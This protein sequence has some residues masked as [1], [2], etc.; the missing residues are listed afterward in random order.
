MQMTGRHF[1][2]I[3]QD[4]SI[5]IS[6]L[7]PKAR[8]SVHRCSCIVTRCTCFVIDG[9]MK[10]NG[11]DT[12]TRDQARVKNESKLLIQA[13]KLTETIILNVPAK[14]AIDN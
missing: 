3:H 6:L 5:Y 10:P 1:L 8:W 4:A 13:D 9:K 2:H 7:T 12:K 11:N 14:Y